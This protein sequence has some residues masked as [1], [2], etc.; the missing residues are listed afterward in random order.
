MNTQHRI[1]VE[2]QVEAFLLEGT[3]LRVDHVGDHFGE[4]HGL[5]VVAQRADVGHGER[6][7]VLDESRQ[8]CGL[9]RERGDCGTVERAHPVLQRLDFGAQYG[10]RRAKLVCDVR[11]PLAAR[12]PRAT[13]RRSERVEIAR[14]LGELVGPVGG[15]AGFVIACDQR[16]GAAREHP[17]PPCEPVRESRSERHRRDEQADGDRAECDALALQVDAFD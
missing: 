3:P 11:N 17:D 10:K 15:D 1:E 14:E 8:T 12:G 7:E 9:V 5:L 4:L 16:M 2:P 6:M 13:Q